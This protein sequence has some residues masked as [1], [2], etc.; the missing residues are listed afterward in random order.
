LTVIEQGKYSGG[1]FIFAAYRIAVDV[2]EGDVLL[3]QSHTQYHGNAPIE[4]EEPNA[5]RISFVTYL[6]K[7]LKRAKNAE[8]SETLSQTN[9]MNIFQSTNP[10]CFCG[11]KPSGK[12]VL[13]DNK[14]CRNE[15]F[16]LSC[17]GSS[18]FLGRWY[19]K[20]CELTISARY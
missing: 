12:M 18:V 8:S 10:F 2:R 9:S 16:H 14:L 19:C 13:C 11:E 17:I 5:K 7:T 15:F 1:Y 20:D 4:I 6:K 3:N